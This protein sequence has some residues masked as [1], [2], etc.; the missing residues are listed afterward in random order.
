MVKETVIRAGRDMAALG[1]KPIGRYEA[2]FLRQMYLQKYSKL[3]DYP[4]E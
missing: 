2:I 1:V 4:E 3:K